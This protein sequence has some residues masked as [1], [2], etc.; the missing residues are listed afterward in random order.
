MAKETVNKLEDRS[1]TIT[2]NAETRDRK[3]EKLRVGW[4]TILF[5]LGLSWFKY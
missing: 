2:K 3:Y 5:C 1:E 4:L